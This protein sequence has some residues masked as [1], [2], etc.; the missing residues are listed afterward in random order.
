MQASC[1]TRT[2]RDA[3][4]SDTASR[5]GQTLQ[6]LARITYYDHAL[7]RHMDSNLAHP[8]L[9]QC[10]GWVVYEDESDLKLVWDRWESVVAG[11]E[12]HADHCGL[13]LRK[14]DVVEVKRLES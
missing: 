1:F 12:E 10:V 7:F 13:A 2:H 6:Y 4:I 5:K 9:R 3:P 14:V 11:Q 8:M